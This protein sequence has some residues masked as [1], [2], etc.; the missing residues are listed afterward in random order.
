MP[1]DCMACSWDELLAQD[2]AEDEE[3]AQAEE[4]SAIS[5]EGDHEASVLAGESDGKE[6][7]PGTLRFYLQHLNDPVHPGASVS[8]LQHCYVCMLE[9][10]RAKAHDNYFDRDCR[11]HKIGAGDVEGNLHPPSLVMMRKILGT[12]AAHQ[13]ERHVCPCDQHVYEYIEPE[14]YREHRADV[15]PK[16]ATP[17]FDLVRVPVLFTWKLHA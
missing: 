1:T 13:C 3:D 17:R 16:C 15:C 10:L 4:H 2:D 14:D 8:L 6:A 11:I 7:P 5:S 9:K 12:R